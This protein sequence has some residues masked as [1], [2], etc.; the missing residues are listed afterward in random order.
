MESLEI[1]AGGDLCLAHGD[2]AALATYRAC[3]ARSSAPTAPFTEAALCVG[4]R[5][6]KSRIL[7]LI[8]VYLATFRDYR[9]HLAPGECATIDGR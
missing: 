5:G 4:R 9:P 3:T 1:R 6:G 2:D 7:A 8:A